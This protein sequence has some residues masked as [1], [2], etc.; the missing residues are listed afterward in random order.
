[1]DGMDTS[2]I[3]EQTPFPDN[4]PGQRLKALRK[5]ADL[6]QTDLSKA[7]EFAGPTG[8]SRFE[9]DERYA[10]ELIPIR[11]IDAIL[12]LLVGRGSP[13]ITALEVLEI[14]EIAGCKSL[15]MI[16]EQGTKVDGT[17]RTT[18]EYEPAFPSETENH[19]YHGM[20]L[21][22][23]FAGQALTGLI[24]ARESS[25]SH[26][27]RADYAHMAY[28]MGEAMARERLRRMELD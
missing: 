27:G 13:P 18:I 23:W 8:Y 19:F 15:S 3:A 9:N 1:M 5:R 20:S 22:D 12:P 2:A 24:S 28:D 14:S 11:I 17:K 21:V 26:E 6:T 10:R 16:L 25:M 4:S 7:C